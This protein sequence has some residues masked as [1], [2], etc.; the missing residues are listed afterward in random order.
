MLMALFNDVREVDDRNRRP[1][2]PLLSGESRLCRRNLS[3]FLSVITIRGTAMIKISP[4]RSSTSCGTRARPELIMM[5]SSIL[6]SLA[7][8][9]HLLA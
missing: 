7:L 4:P 8:L 3:W 5:N 9:A 2:R 1:T 6:L